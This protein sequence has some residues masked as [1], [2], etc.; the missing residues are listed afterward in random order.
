MTGSMGLSIFAGVLEQLTVFVSSDTGRCLFAAAVGTPVVALF[1]PSDSEPLRPALGSRAGGH[2][3]LVVSPVTASGS[4]PNDAAA[5][6]QTVCEA[7]TP[8]WSGAR[9]AT[10]CNPIDMC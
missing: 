6:C 1:G 5:E 3:G 10:C 2:R 9:P 8:T 7:S 4:L